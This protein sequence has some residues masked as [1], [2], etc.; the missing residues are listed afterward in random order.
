M[1]CKI[2][3][4]QQEHFSQF[5]LNVTEKPAPV[6]AIRSNPVHRGFAVVMVVRLAVWRLL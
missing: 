1:G 2:Y 6:S 5:V 3:L 4:P